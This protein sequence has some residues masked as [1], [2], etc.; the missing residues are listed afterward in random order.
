MP[1]GLTSST[2]KKEKKKERKKGQCRKEAEVGDNQ[3]NHFWKRQ[4]DLGPGY[5]RKSQLG[6]GAHP[7]VWKEE[8]RLVL[9]LKWLPLSNDGF[10]FPEDKQSEAPSQE[11]EGGGMSAERNVCV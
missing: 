4:K 3:I 5:L 10:H 1:L 9:R 11:W 8:R 2:E 7:P 6:G